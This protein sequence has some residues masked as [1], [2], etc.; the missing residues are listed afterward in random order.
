MNL[1][2]APG[3]NETDSRL[4]TMEDIKKVYRDLSKKHHPDKGGDPS[5]FNA[6]T[7]AYDVLSNP[8]RRKRYDAIGEHD[9]NAGHGAGEILRQRSKQAEI[10]GGVRDSASKGLEIRERERGNDGEKHQAAVGTNW[11]QS[12]PDV[13]R[14]AD[15]VPNR[16]DRLR[17]LGNAVVPQI[18][19]LIGNAILASLAQQE[20]A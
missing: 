12:E 11:W 6:I 7:K 18:P 20:A 9:D 15:G 4:F 1:Y 5:I 10:F 14:V 2:E 16:V 13:G 3:I 19:E 17:A 8:E